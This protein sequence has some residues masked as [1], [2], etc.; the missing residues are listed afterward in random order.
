M[1][2]VS[3]GDGDDPMSAA[4][5]MSEAL[6]ED[7]PAVAEKKQ[8]SEPKKLGDVKIEASLDAATSSSSPFKGTPLPADFRLR[9]LSRRRRSNY[10]GLTRS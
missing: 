4:R 6:K 10:R 2:E 1:G 8:R 5:K 7:P 9:L 3:I